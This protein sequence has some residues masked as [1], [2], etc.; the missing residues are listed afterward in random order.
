MDPAVVTAAGPRLDPRRAGRNDRE[1]WLSPAAGR[2]RRVIRL[3]AVDG[4]RSLRSV[5]LPL[6]QLTVVTGANGTGKSGVY[7][8]LALL[9]SAARGELV[10]AL[11]A[12]GGLSSTLWAGPEQISGAMRRGEVP[13]QGTTRK[14]PVALRIGF[15][16]DRLSYAVDLGIPVQSRLTMFNR[17]PQLKVEAVWAGPTLRPATLLS[18][19][20]GPLVRVRSDAGWE[21]VTKDLP[22]FDSMLDQVGDPRSAADVIA[23]RESMRSWR[24][25]DQIRTDPG[26]PARTGSVGTRTFALAADGH[27]LAAALATIREN[28]PVERLAGTVDAAFPG[29]ELEIVENDGV[30]DVAL[31]QPGM[32]RPLRAAELSDGTLRF[33][34]WTAALLSPRPPELLVLNEPENSLHPQL[35]PALAE[36]VTSTARTTQVLLITHSERFLAALRPAADGLETSEIELVKELG[37]TLVAGRDELFVSGWTW[38]K[39]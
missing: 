2:L 9:A 19:R 36:L 28:A 27:D 4:Y 25:Y 38:P 29:T 23:V 39:R 13:V 7:R 16:S 37:E 22:H 21:V 31:R 15:A 12:Q 1:P 14:N 6:G 24:F 11:A 8:V 5:R 26:S 3:I 10:A 18:E 30:F 33:L 34:A 32:L 20:R 17:D 35:L